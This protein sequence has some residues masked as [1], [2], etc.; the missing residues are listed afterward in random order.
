MRIDLL[1][2]DGTTIEV[3]RG[4]YGEFRQP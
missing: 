4:G 2:G 3:A 1:M